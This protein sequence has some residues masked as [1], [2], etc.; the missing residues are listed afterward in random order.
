M[1]EKETLMHL[2]STPRSEEEIELERENLIAKRNLLW[3]IISEKSR[4]LPEYK[5]MLNINNILN[6][7]MIQL[8]DED[9]KNELD[10]ASKQITEEQF[11]EIT[12]SFTDEKKYVEFLKA[13]KGYKNE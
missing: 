2:D 12:R 8:S 10:A 5:E 9:R 3:A 4:Q 1:K 7:R 13:Y 11:E 6:T